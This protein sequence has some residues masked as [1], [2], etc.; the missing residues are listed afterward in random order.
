[1]PHEIEILVNMLFESSTSGIGKLWSMGQIQSVTCFC[2]VNELRMFFYIFLIECIGVTLVKK[3][4]FNCTIIMHHLYIEFYETV[5][6]S[7]IHD[8]YIFTWL[9]TIKKNVLLNI[10]LYKI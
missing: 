1:M 7:I 10:K 6:C 8:F 4:G 5:N 9:K 2:T 3:L